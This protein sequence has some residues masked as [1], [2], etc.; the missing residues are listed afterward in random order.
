MSTS[1]APPAASPASDDPATGPEPWSAVFALGVTQIASWGSIYYGFSVL[2]DPMQAALRTSKDAVVG[3]FCLALLLSGLAA[4][5]V[6]RT[7]DRVGGRRLMTAGS[8]AA[9][10]FFAW[11]SR[12][13]SVVELYVI[14]AGLGLAM[15]ATLYDPAFA[16]LVRAFHTHHRK[17]ITT[18]TLFGGL[19]STVF[20]P[21]TQALVTRLGWRDAAL[22]LALVNLL[23]CAPIHFLCLPRDQARARPPQAAAAPR[24]LGGSVWSPALMLVAAAFTASGVVVSAV[25]VHLL[26][27]LTQRGLTPG[28]AAMVGAVIGPMQVAG[29]I[30]EFGLKG[31]VSA[32]GVGIAVFAMLPLSML[33]LMLAGGSAGLAVLFAVLYGASNGVMTIVRG[34]LPA[35]LFG[36]ERYGEIN[37]A[38]AAPALFARASGPLVASL[39]LGLAG[40]YGGV[41]WALLVAALLATACFLAVKPRTGRAPA[42]SVSERLIP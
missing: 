3:A 28:Q 27:L 11:L 39:A 18:L 21:L 31:R 25:S 37:G 1:A 6:G 32:R 26:S 24:G 22:G 9:A 7:I 15:A 12:A 10:L 17:A 29:R 23:V 33:V 38:I 41:L 16:V 40:G 8:I 42:A 2:M 5:A 36:R 30:A 19:A 13:S 34:T 20:W 4:P 35:E 14:W